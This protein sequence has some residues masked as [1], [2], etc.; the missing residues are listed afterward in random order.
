MSYYDAIEVR[1][2]QARAGL[3]E[4]NRALIESNRALIAAESR[5]VELEA[6]L[7]QADKL[8]SKVRD[9]AYSDGGFADV[10]N[11]LAVWDGE[12]A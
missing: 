10:Q 12:G 7:E 6:R 3:E 9:F 2:K 8:A 4:S 5:V 11:A 1:L